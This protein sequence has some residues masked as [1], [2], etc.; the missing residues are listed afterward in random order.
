MHWRCKG[1][2][3]GNVIDVSLQCTIAVQFETLEDK[4]KGACVYLC[5]S[6][7]PLATLVVAPLPHNQPVGYRHDLQGTLTDP[8]HP[9]EKVHPA[10]TV[11]IH[12]TQLSH[13]GEPVFGRELNSAGRK[14][15][16]A[17]LASVALQA[18]EAIRWRPDGN[19]RT[20]RI[21]G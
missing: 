11:V 19:A 5:H 16:S 20:G 9:I 4:C 13:E 3:H 14:I 8:F 21:C 10:Y 17:P 6:S 7:H 15:E 12:R 2:C 1:A 18:C